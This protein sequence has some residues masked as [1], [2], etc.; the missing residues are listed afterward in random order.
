[1]VIFLEAYVKN[2]RLV[3]FI[4]G[5]ISLG[6]IALAAVL[7]F[8]GPDRIDLSGRGISDLLQGDEAAGIIA[9]PIVLVI[10]AL[11]MWSVFRTISPPKIKNGVTAAARVLEVHDTGV[12]VNDNPQVRLVIEVMPKSGSRFQA[13]VKTL[14]SRLEAALVQPGVEAVVVYDPLRPTRLQLSSMDLKPVERNN[15][16]SRLKE[17]EQLYEERLITNDEY[18]TKREEIIRK[19]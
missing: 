19:L 13:Q 11:V 2:L 3:L 16:E 5:L 1:M 9:I 10:T 17:L 6:G 8:T 15:A 12:S 7:I 18:R 4:S 14:V